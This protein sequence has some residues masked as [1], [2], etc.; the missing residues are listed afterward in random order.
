MEN[1][2]DD[3]PSAPPPSPMITRKLFTHDID[4]S[5]IKNDYELQDILKMMDIHQID[6]SG[7][8]LEDRFETALCN[9]SALDNEI[10]KIKMKLLYII[11]ANNM[12]RSM[13]EELKQY[14]SKK[15]KP[16]YRGFSV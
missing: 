11:I 2:F 16:L 12:Y 7:V 9:H 14:H 13:V 15:N 4:V 6:I 8:R 1:T 5:I 3:T 10:T